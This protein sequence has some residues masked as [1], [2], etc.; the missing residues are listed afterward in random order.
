MPREDSKSQESEE[1]MKL[2]DAKH[3]A[4]LMQWRE[5]VQS[6][7]SSGQSV[8]GWCREHNI[9]V[10]TYYRRQKQVW[11]R[12]SQELPEELNRRQALQVVGENYP[13]AVFE[14]VP[15]RASHPEELS[16]KVQITLRKGEWTLEIRNGAEGE[17]LRQIIEVLQ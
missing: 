4:M 1:K 2:Q 12:D 15:C 13:A 8:T 5:M 10:T 6:C 14:A 11:E 16:G 17:L 3:E 7:R 9:P